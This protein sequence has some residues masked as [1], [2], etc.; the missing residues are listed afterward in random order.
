[1]KIRFGCVLAGML[2]LL[3]AAF[4]AGADADTAK[5]LLILADVSGSML[6]DMKLYETAADRKNDKDEKSVQKVE[7]LK[8]M[9][10]KMG[11]TLASGPCDL[12][13]YRVRYIAGNETRYAR[14][15]AVDRHEPS[16]LKE[17]I[18]DDF[19][20]D[21]PLYNRRT[22]LADMFRQ[23]DENELADT[24]GNITLV[25]LS[26]GRESFYD[27]EDDAEKSRDGEVGDDD[28]TAGP[29]TEVLRLKQKYGRNLVVHTVFFGDTDEETRESADEVRAFF[30]DAAGDGK[31][32]EGENL[33]HRMAW[34][35]QGQYRRAADLLE[36]PAALAAFCGLLCDA[37]ETPAPVKTE[38]AAPVA[39]TT[40][41]VAPAD[42]DGDGIRDDADQCPDTPNGAH[43]TSAGCWILI[44]VLFD[45]DKWDIRPEFHGPLDE[46][47]RVM[48]DN[49][50]LKLSIQ[51]HTDSRASA[52]HNQ[53]LSRKRAEAVANW[54]TGKGVA[55]DRLSAEAHGL[56]QPLATNST[57]E[58]RTLN[59]RVELIPV[60][61]ETGE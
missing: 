43:V 32:A 22:D 23:L 18:E 10:L 34:L 36:D 2:L 50:D 49:P 15:V 38:A 4:P 25:L 37:E 3:C 61:A 29:L 6:R 20:I 59:R 16:D 45:T 47:S 19:V 54:L 48:R 60:L 5:P 44:G 31:K 33:L 55:P 13:I 41:A 56:T 1:M 51:G 21:Y 46:V 35:G 40:A 12:G 42:R 24:D 17:R 28:P 39:V 52:A 27:P 7:A 9:L 11:Q 26:D 8:A 58:G 57:P 53:V 30:E 14:F